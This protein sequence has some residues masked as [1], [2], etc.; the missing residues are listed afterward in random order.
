MKA[1]FKDVIASKTKQALGS[2]LISLEAIKQNIQILEELRDFIPP[3]S[4]EES[5]QLEQNILKYGCKDAVE[6][7]TFLLSK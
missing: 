1:N 5:Q 6:T 2:N 4:D 7:F 3:L